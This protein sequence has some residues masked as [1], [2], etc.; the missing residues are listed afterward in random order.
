MRSQF[1]FCFV[2]FFF[3]RKAIDQK[4]I[5]LQC[6]V[7]CS[8]KSLFFL[9]TFIS[10]LIPFLF[11]LRADLTKNSWFQVPTHFSFAA[12]SLR[13]SSVKWDGRNFY[14]GQWFLLL[15]AYNLALKCANPNGIFDVTVFYKLW[16]TE[17]VDGLQHTF[18]GS[19]LLTLRTRCL[20][21]SLT[22]KGIRQWI[23][24]SFNHTL[25]NFICQFT[26]IRENNNIE[27]LSLKIWTARSLDHLK[28]CGQW[29]R[30][31]KTFYKIQLNKRY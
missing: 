24:Q 25:F 12:S 3:L 10:Y 29:S 20:N 8:S 2:F 30:W 27:K 18:P 11:F 26:V 9:F 14:W 31:P 15:I 13:S 19:S 1:L 22:G 21:T 5:F 17:N 7:I 16:V 28:S 23:N 6:G 4:I